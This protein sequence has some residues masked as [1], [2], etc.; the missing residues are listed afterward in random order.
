MW[1]P[2]W[3]WDIAC[4]QENGKSNL[5]IDLNS[6]Q[7][8]PG[9]PSSVFHGWEIWSTDL[10]QWDWVAGVFFWIFIPHYSSREWNVF[11]QHSLWEDSSR[12]VSTKKYYSEWTMLYLGRYFCYSA[13]RLHLGS[14]IFFAH[15]SSQT[16][17][18]KCNVN[19]FA[20]DALLFTV[21]EDPNTAANDMSNDLE[22]MRQWT[23]N[24][25]ISLN[26]DR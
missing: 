12:M 14:F 7:R 4:W 16:G 19:L 2:Q 22:L 25:N 8:I 1:H 17:G 3:F 11:A 13:S 23:R 5:G 24:W 18:L 15:I 9:E 26:P 20:D 21:L 10:S 6:K